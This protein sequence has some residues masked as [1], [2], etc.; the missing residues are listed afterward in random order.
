MNSSAATTNTQKTLVFCNS[1]IAWGGGEKWHLDAAMAMAERGFRV[2]LLCHPQGKLYA[3][4][5]SVSGI[6]VLPLSIGRLSFLNPLQGW[7]LESFFRREGVSAVVM[8]L[9]QDMKCVAPAA[10]RA[11]VEHVIYRRGSALPVKNSALN[12]RLYGRILTGLIVNSQ[13]T[14]AAT[15]QNNPSLIAEDRITLLPNGM[16]IELFDAG[17]QKNCAPLLPGDTPPLVLGTAGRLNRQKAQHLFLYLGKTLLEQGVN[18]RLVLAG[19]GEL[20]GELRGLAARLGLEGHVVFTGFLDDLAPFWQAVDIFVLTSLWEGF[21][22]VLLEAMLAR[23]PIVAFGTSN[24]PE[25]VRHGD[26][27]LLF[28]LPGAQASVSD[29]QAPV[30]GSLASGPDMAPMAGGILRLARSPGMRQQMGEAGRAFAVGHFDQKVCMDRL[31]ALLG[32]VKTDL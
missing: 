24:I 17:M 31:E 28:P 8:N 26:N 2:F 18:C 15:L 4:A 9:P 10:R 3:K 12:R 32:S 7:Q 19:T 20:E 29:A 5:Q 30:S 16:D 6:A 27:G 11:G 13:A 25:L 22:F 14:R 21:G 23:K 1:T